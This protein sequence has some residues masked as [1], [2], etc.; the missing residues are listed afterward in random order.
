LDWAEALSKAKI[1]M[2]SKRVADIN[3][4]HDFLLIDENRRKFFM[5]FYLTINNNQK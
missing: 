2:K 1:A 4:Q 3:E 5:I